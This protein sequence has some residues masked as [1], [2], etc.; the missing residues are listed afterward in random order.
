MSGTNDFLPFGTA[1]GAPVLTQSA[2]VS[3]IP[4]NGRGPGVVPKESYNKTL[5]QATSVAAM[6]GTFISGAGFNAV[7]DGNIAALT[8]AFLSALGTLGIQLSAFTGSNQDLASDGYQ[9]LPGGL[10]IQWV[11]GNIPGPSAGSVTWPIPF[12]NACFAP[13]I[14]AIGTP[15]VDTPPM[16]VSSNLTGAVIDS[17]LDAFDVVVFAFGN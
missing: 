17:K 14:S 2:Y 3:S 9:K 10:I 13:F 11:H 5:R 1:S 12:P 8:T 6:I 16:V 15:L 7:D 4:A